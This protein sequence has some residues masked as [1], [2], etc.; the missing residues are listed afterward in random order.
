MLIY[1][2]RRWHSGRASTKIAL[3]SDEARNGGMLAHAETQNRQRSE[4]RVHEE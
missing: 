3:E 4:G 1:Q 2:P